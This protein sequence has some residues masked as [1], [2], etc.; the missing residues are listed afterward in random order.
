MK[1][2]QVEHPLIPVR[3]ALQGAGASARGLALLQRR[4]QRAPGVD[5]RAEP[6]PQGHGRTGIKGELHL[7]IR[8]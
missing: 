3:R 7:S 4:L 5:L 6:H 2:A 8:M 1:I